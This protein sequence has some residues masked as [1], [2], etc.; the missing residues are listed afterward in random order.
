MIVGTSDSLSDI[1]SIFVN[2][3]VQKRG[4]WSPKI[5]GLR[6][7]VECFSRAMRCLFAIMSLYDYTST[8][9]SY[10]TF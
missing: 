8:K 4:I 2:I 6:R 9:I 1:I 3:P 5:M 10:R 7:E